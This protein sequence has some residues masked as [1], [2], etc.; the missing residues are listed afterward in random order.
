LDE[1]HP[2]CLVQREWRSQGFA[3]IT[4]DLTEQHR[5]DTLLRSV[6]DHTI[7]SI[8]CIDQH[9]TIETFNAA[10]ERAFGY[11]Q[12]EVIGKNVNILMPDPY[13]SQ[14]DSYIANYLQTGVAKIIGIERVIECCRKDGALFPAAIRV[15]EFR[16]EVDG[17]H[18]FTGVVHD[19]SEKRVAEAQLG[20]EK[21]FS[22]TLLESLP[23]PVYLIDAQGRFVRWNRATEVATGYSASELANMMVLDLIPAETKG[24]I[25][26]QLNAVFKDGKATSEGEIMSKDG[27]RTDFVL[28]GVRLQVGEETYCIGLGMDI[29]ERK[30]LEAQLQQSQKMEAFGQLAG[31]VAHDFNNLLTVILGFSEI[32]LSQFPKSDP[33]RNFLEQ[34]HHAGER[35]ASLTRQLLAFSRQQVLEPKVLN[36][37]AIVNDTEKMLRR[38][39]GEDVELVAVLSPTLSPVKVD[40][41][42]IDQVIMNLAVNARDAMPQGGTL[43]I[44]TQ[45][46]ELDEAYA[47]THSEVQPGRFVLLA[48]TDTG[49]GMTPE[50]KAR[51]FEPFYTTKDVG[52]GTGLGLAVVQGIVKQSRGSI[53][54]YS[55]V[56]SGTTFKIYIPAVQERPTSLSSSGLT[57]PILGTETILLVE[58][59]DAV[60]ELTALALQGSGYTVLK[61]SRGKDALRLMEGRT[62]RIDLLVTDVVMPEMSGSKLAEALQS[63]YPGLKVLFLSGYMDDAVFRHGILQDKVAFLQKPFTVTSLAKKV[64]EVLDKTP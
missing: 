34:I 41:G 3:K 29:T 61:E 36:L 2:D 25:G 21:A 5:E 51:I 58:D 6:L 16:T 55:E 49:S 13:R 56:G 38:L 62:E 32:L 31:G 48:M 14:H 42:Q 45:N 53:E 18:H 20:K 1:R 24:Y 47:K 40:P 37:N 15:S 30:K 57:K 39:I 43:T 50:V 11:S 64:R 9:G 22:D 28:S 54:V 23:G 46:V 26:E 60:R 10:A 7:D 63:R 4:S 52:K 59:E 35:A 33:K 17:S 8:V 44:E 19:L 12:V 27:T